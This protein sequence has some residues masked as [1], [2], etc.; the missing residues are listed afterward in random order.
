MTDIKNSSR[1]QIYTP[2]ENAIRFKRVAER[3]VN[4]LLNDLRLLG[5]TSNKSLYRYEE[6]EVE[7]IFATLTQ[8]ITEVRGK[9]RSRKV[10]NKFRLD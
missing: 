4:R 2:E 9:F 5:N 1:E 8:A 3:R 7:K 10:K 6:A